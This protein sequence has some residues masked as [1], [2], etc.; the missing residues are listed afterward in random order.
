MTVDS[1]YLKAYTQG[2]FAVSTDTGTIETLSTSE[3]SLFYNL[4][5]AIVSKDITGMTIDT[6]LVD[7]LTCLQICDRIASDGK[8]DLTGEKQGLDS[9]YT[10]N[11]GKT[12][13]M[14]RYDEILLNART[15]RAPRLISTEHDDS[16]IIDTGLLI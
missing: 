13:W 3:F 9:S 1:S 5:S 8:D 14:V 2:K 4:A 7:E 15:A 12:G 6:Y 10:R 11:A 16:T